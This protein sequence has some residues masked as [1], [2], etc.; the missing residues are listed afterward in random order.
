[1]DNTKFI[2]CFIKATKENFELLLNLGFERE[3]TNV[4]ENGINSNGCFLIK[5]DGIISYQGNWEYTIYL[6]EDPEFSE[7][8]YLNNEWIVLKQSKL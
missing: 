3:Y 5:P 2:N 8:M 7:I 4:M 1:M 6:K